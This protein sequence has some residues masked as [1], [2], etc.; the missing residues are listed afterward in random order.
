MLVLDPTASLQAA[1]VATIV[2]QN[3]WALLLPFF[4]VL[5]N[6]G[7]WQALVSWQGD[8]QNINFKPM[9]NAF[10]PLASLQVRQLIGPDCC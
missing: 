10:I 6:P 4:P 2:A 1:D 9:A 7:A 3:E 5:G 8:S